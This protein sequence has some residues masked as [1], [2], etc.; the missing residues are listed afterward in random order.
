MI[1]VIVNRP[2]L[3]IGF[4]ALLEL[5]NSRCRFLRGKRRAGNCLLISQVLQPC[6]Q[7]HSQRGRS[8]LE[9]R[10]LLIVTVI[11]QELLPACFQ[12]NAYLGALAHELHP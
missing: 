7:C 2:A 12:R 9:R 4:H 6:I 10:R 1:D 8:R 5:E 11:R 3:G